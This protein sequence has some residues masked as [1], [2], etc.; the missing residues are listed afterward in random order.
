ME[1]LGEDV[2]ANEVGEFFKQIGIIKVVRPPPSSSPYR[3]HAPAHHRPSSV[4]PLHHLLIFLVCHLVLLF[5]LRLLIFINLLPYYFY[6][7]HCPYLPSAPSSSSSP[8]SL[9]SPSYSSTVISILFYTAAS[10][11]LGSAAGSLTV[12]VDPPASKSFFCPV[13]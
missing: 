10:T 9:F 3:P 13:R 1:G 12:L 7:I 6:P 5:L 2:T 11:S 4:P 8:K